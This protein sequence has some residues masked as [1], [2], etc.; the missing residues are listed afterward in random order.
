[1]EYYINENK[2]S[3]ELLLKVKNAWKN[4]EYEYNLERKLWDKERKN[5]MIDI[6]N[7]RATKY[8]EMEEMAM[9]HLEEKRALRQQLREAH[10]SESAND[11]ISS[12]QLSVG[13]LEEELSTA[14]LKL[15]EMNQSQA[16]KDSQINKLNAELQLADK[17][18][19]ERAKLAR[20]EVN[21]RQELLKKIDEQEKLICHLKHSYEDVMENLT[22]MQ[23]E[24]NDLE[25][26][27]WCYF[28]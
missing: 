11:A 12:L 27:V 5:F 13:K 28:Y 23:N 6:Y 21:D 17:K 20:D 15:S 19:E 2:T 14:R 9:K 22:A 16:E 3:D 25:E 1:M 26:K 18:L 7:L 24:K 8:N 10:T 4:D